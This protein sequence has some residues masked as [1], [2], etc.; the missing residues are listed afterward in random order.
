MIVNTNGIVINDN[1]CDIKAI[2]LASVTS[3]SYAFKTITEFRPKG[4]ANEH[5]IHNFKL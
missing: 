4:I 3:Y 2:A 1:M 5:I